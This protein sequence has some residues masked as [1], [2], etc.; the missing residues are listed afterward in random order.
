MR[1]T[2]STVAGI[3]LTL[4][5]GAAFA[6]GYPARAVTLVVPTAPGGGTDFI[7]RLLAEALR[8]RLGGTVVVDNRGGA[9]GTIAAEYV[10]RAAA[11][12][13]LVFISTPS[14]IVIAPNV[15]KNLRYDALKDFAAV[16]LAGETPLAFVAHPS[17]PVRTVDEVIR[18]SRRMPGTLSYGTPGASTPQNIAGAWLV[19]RTGMDLVM[20]PY[21]GAGPA[22]I[23]VI[24]GQ[25]PF[26]VLG[27]API[28]PQVKAGKLRAIAVMSKARVPWLPDVPVVAESTGMKDFS[29]VNWL[30]VQVH[31][32]TP[33]E[34]V[35]RLNREIVEVLKSADIRRILLEQGIDP[36]GNTPEEF[37]AFL[38]EEF[39]KYAELVKLAGLK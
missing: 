11:D 39:R 35:R 7:A 14:S 26:A 36:V 33:P 13:H 10:T 15:E 37:S 8:P 18:L 30:G 3:F 29:V 2:L 6:Q 5:V 34:T 1:R 21:K 23:D 19:K 27:M 16:T 12:G 4:A 20:V 31:A 38:N 25:I 24:G 22:T 9:S 28:L 32:K 17:V